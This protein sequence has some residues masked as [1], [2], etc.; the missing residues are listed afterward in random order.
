MDAWIAIAGCGCL[1][2]T[3][4]ELARLAAR[5]ASRDRAR[6][7]D[8]RTG[9]PLRLRPDRRRAG[10]RKLDGGAGPRVRP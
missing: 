8:L 9:R 2:W 3:A 7:R 6:A 1:G 10:R 4:L 5:A